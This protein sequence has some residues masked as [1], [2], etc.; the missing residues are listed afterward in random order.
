MFAN[1]GN[2]FPSLLSRVYR[3]EIPVD[4]GVKCHDRSGT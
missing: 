3:D 2:A 1:R 4:I